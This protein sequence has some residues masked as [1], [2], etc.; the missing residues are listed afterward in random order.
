MM[1][2]RGIGASP[3]AARS[4]AATSAVWASSMRPIAACD[5]ASNIC[6]PSRSPAGASAGSSRSAASN[7][8][9]ALAGARPAASVAGVAQDR[10]SLEVAATGGMQHVMGALARRGAPRRE[11]LRGALV[12][13]QPRPGGGGVVDRAPDQRMAELERPRHDAG[14]DDVALD[15]LVDQR[16]CFGFVHPRGVDRHVE[17][18]WVPGDRGGVTERPRLWRERLEL[19]GDRRGDDGGYRSLAVADARSDSLRIAGPGE[20]EHVERVAAARLVQAVPRRR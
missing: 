12:R 15:Q 19:G 2:S 18:E 10:D 8:R 7:H 16:E 3:S 9:A 17:V 5:P 1:R 13:G 6:R 20:L 4:I 11:R 14:A